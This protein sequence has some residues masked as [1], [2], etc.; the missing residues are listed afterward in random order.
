VWTGARVPRKRVEMTFK[1]S[2]VTNVKM[3]KY[4]DVEAASQAD[5]VEE[6]KRRI[7]LAKDIP[8]H[9]DELEIDPAVYALTQTSLEEAIWQI[10]RQ[11]AP[12]SFSAPTEW[13]PFTFG[14]FHGVEVDEEDLRI[15]ATSNERLTRPELCILRGLRGWDQLGEAPDSSKRQR[16]N[17]S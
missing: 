17:A 14:K 9:P 11:S 12:Q 7:E 15:R 5:A 1:V 6:V 10:G 2:V 3:F 8:R 16:G 13:L 4:V